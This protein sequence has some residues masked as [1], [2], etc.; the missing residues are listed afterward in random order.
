MAFEGKRKHKALPPAM[1]ECIRAHI[2]ASLD[3]DLSTNA[4]ATMIHRTPSSFCR[5]FRATFGTTAT[6]YVRKRRLE[7]ACL[8]MLETRLPLTLIALECGLYD[9]PHLCRC[10]R[11]HF[12]TPPGRWRKSTLASMF[13]EMSG[14]SRSDELSSIGAS[15]CLGANRGERRDQRPAQPAEAC[16]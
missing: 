7:R 6:S 13:S 1:A 3:A 15:P 2:H 11:D 5:A 14:V 12:G 16:P 9:Q 8:L 10:F 4:L